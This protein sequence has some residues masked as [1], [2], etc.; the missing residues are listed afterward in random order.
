[1]LWLGMPVFN[2]FRSTAAE[3][4]GGAKCSDAIGAWWAV[5]TIN[6]CLIL[7]II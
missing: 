7:G 3:I 4:D 5:H 1:M 2:L 6:E